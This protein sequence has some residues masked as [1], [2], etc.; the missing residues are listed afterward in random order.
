MLNLSVA[1]CP[2]MSN[3]D[4]EKVSFFFFKYMISCMPSQR[5]L[6]FFLFIPNTSYN[7][8]VYRL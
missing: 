4:G 3:D 2:F 8:F 5:A 1:V 6:Y 7:E